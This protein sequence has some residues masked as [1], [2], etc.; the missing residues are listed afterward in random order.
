MHF[1]RLLLTT[2]LLF[3]AFAGCREDA[4]KDEP[5]LPPLPPAVPQAAGSAL[6]AP[7]PAPE[8]P[9]ASTVEMGD[10]ALAPQLLRGFHAVENGWRW[11]DQAFAVKLGVPAGA[12]ERGG[13]LSLKFSLPA[14]ALQKNKAVTVKAKVGDATAS[15]TVSKPDAET[16]ELDLPGTALSSSSV[17]VEFSTD[18]TFAPGGQDI[19]SLG[20]IALSVDLVA[21]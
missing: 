7:A 10:Q 5:P 19:R 12:S 9:L 18:K 15:K 11:T 21:K 20:V 17:V 16:L 14:P 4:S 3:P 2:V 1:S 13:K 8:P 6:P